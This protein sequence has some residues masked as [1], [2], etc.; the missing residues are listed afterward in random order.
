[1]DALIFKNQSQQR[2]TPID[3]VLNYMRD[4][5]F[6]VSDT[7]QIIDMNA[8]AKTL[9]QTFSET[10]V[11]LHSFFSDTSLK[12]L[13]SISS[14]LLHAK[15]LK[16]EL[17]AHFRQG[18]LTF[19]THWIPLHAQ[20]TQWL[21]ICEDITEKKQFQTHIMRV[22]RMQSMGVLAS[23]I[24]HDI[25]NIL[26]M[27]FM[28][29]HTLKKQN[30]DEN[31]KKV[32]DMMENSTRQGVQLTRQ[33]MDFVKGVDKEKETVDIEKIAQDVMGLF[34]QTLP[35]IVSIQSS[36]GA[37]LFS[38]SGYGNQ[39]QQILL[40][41]CVNAR[42]ALTLEGGVIS[43][44]AQNTFLSQAPLYVIGEFQFR[45]GNYVRVGVS[46][47]GPG[48]PDDMRSRI[49]EPFFSTKPSD[50]GTG[51]G[52]AMVKEMIHT[53][54]GFIEVISEQNKGTQFYVYLPAIPE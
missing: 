36:V 1:M 39:I 21:V 32:L 47:T 38:V 22:Q 4:A 7:L 51:L 42:D 12:H 25:N 26:A 15:S 54:K 13:D 37:E 30:L 45:A 20:P 48:I 6:V 49:F 11:S 31:G 43:I 23:G 29:F 46:D 14:Q 44:E 53:H 35:Q 17:T 27:F 9:V 40:N 28:A 50:K 2:V 16:V 34:Q 24:A 18:E 3:T 8:K 41:L 52:L 5:V 33:L 10:P 19:E